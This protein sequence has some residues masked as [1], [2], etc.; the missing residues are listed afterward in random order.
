VEQGARDQQHRLCAGVPNLSADET[1]RLDY[2]LLDYDRT[3]NFTLNAIWQTPSVTSN[4]GLGVLVNDWQ[5]SA[6]TGGRAA[7]P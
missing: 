2:S 3:H 5:L 7:G 4:R 1:R 6:S